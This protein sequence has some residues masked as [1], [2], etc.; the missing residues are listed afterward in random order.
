MTMPNERLKY[1][2]IALDGANEE[3]LTVLATATA[4]MLVEEL[5]GVGIKHGAEVLIDIGDA[6]PDKAMV[7]FEW[8]IK[9]GKDDGPQ[10]SNQ[11][12]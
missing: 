11:G 5:I 3:E 8:E 2:E 7:V 4:A 6:K 1:L 10:E 12:T 9:E